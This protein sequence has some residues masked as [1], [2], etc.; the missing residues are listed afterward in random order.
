MIGCYRLLDVHLSAEFLNV[1]KVKFVPTAEIIFLDNPHFIHVRLV[2]CA[3]SFAGRPATFLQLG[4]CL[5]KLQYKE[6]FLLTINMSA[7]STYQGL[8]GIP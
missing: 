1:Y 2:V 6:G 8:Y 4:T 5:N 3:R 7:V